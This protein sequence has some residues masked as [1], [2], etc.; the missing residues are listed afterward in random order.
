MPNMTI[1]L[2]NETHAKFTLLEWKKQREI[3]EKL[4]KIVEEEVSQ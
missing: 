2:K 3:R 4:T 1:Y